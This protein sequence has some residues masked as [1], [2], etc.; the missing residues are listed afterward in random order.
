MKTAQQAAANWLASQGRATQAY[1][2][3][4]QSYSGDWSGATT[5]QEAALLTNVTQAITS[6][7][8]RSGVTSVGTSGWKS[9]TQ[10][11]A[12]NYGTGFAAGA[13]KQ[14]SAIAKI[15]S[16]EQSIVPALPARG[17]FE[18]NVQRSVSFQTAMHQLRGQ[19]KG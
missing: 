16:A 13:Q 6:G 8:W 14:A 11:K 3:G 5:A 17:T 15:I 4:V 12:S 2:D 10:A 18:Q 9:A 7:R 1:T 19:L